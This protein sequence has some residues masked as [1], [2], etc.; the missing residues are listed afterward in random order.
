[1]FRISSDTI[2]GTSKNLPDIRKD[3]RDKNKWWIKLPEEWSNRK[4]KDNVLG[5]R[6]IYQIKDWYDIQ[7]KFFIRFLILDSPI[8]G[9]NYICHIK[10]L[11]IGRDTTLKEICDYF[12]GIIQGFIDYSSITIDT[13]TVNPSSYSL[14]H[15]PIN[16]YC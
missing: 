5:I 14:E 13:E 12:N 1:L 9:V 3:T 10:N 2:V 16:N 6:N 7:F 15:Y 11:F 8:K 4:F